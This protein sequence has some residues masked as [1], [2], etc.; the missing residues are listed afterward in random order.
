M[1][2]KKEIKSL[3]RMESIIKCVYF[4]DNLWEGEL[5]LILQI[6]SIKMDGR[7]SGINYIFIVIRISKKSTKKVAEGKLICL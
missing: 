4:C 5:L 6:D 3:F 1:N 7:R 2:E